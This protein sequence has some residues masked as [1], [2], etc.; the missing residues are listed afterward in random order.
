MSIGILG[1]KIGMTQIFDNNGL[2]I[3]ISVIKA[4]PCIITQIKEISRNGY[5]AIQIGFSK[6]KNKKIKRSEEGHFLK[7]SNKVFSFLKE[8]HVTKPEIFMLGQEITI[9]DFQVK[10]LVNISGKNIG[11]GF[12]SL[13]KR[14]HFARGPM[15]HGSKNHR[16]PGSIGAGTTPGRVFP[17][18]KMSGHLGNKNITITNLEIIAV[19]NKEN[20]LLIKG[21]VP[22]KSGNLV[23]IIPS[24]IKSK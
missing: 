18:K 11:K 24:V 13:Q 9:K 12:S 5:N 21:T 14:H 16:A 10:Q 3:P 1:I 8:Y 22:G 4:G 6:K 7:S 17:G 20:L 23:S 19:D 2:A 15:T